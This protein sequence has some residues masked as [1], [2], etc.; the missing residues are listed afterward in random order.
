MQISSKISFGYT[1]L[2]LNSK[3]LVSL[4]A[5]KLSL[6]PTSL[7]YPLTSLVN[8]S[9]TTTDKFYFAKSLSFG[10]ID[11]MFGAHN[12]TGN[13]TFEGNT[14]R[15]YFSRLDSYE[16]FE[17]VRCQVGKQL[18]EGLGSESL[19]VEIA[20]VEYYTKGELVLGIYQGTLD[21]QIEELQQ[22]VIQS[23]VQEIVTEQLVLD[24]DYYR[25]LYRNQTNMFQTS[26]RIFGGN[27]VGLVNKDQYEIL[28]SSDYTSY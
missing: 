14:T 22:S 13:C 8:V 7:P 12:L 23:E 3:T 19:Q 11:V 16:D 27:I 15:T 25:F 10:R 21:I 17:Y 5:G 24:G 6:T 28:N 9:L 18:Y 2:R 4:T 1:Q 26:A 20:V